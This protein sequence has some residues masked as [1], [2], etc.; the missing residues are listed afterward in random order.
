MR[1]EG[2][3]IIGYSKQ[4]GAKFKKQYIENAFEI[5]TLMSLVCLGDLLSLR[6]RYLQHLPL[7]MIS[8]STSPTICFAASANRSSLIFRLRSYLSTYK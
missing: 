4:L 8:S 7:N 5:Q 2:L 6:N 3:T 1:L